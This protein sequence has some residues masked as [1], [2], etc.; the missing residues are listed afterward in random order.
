MW[1]SKKNL[2]RKVLKVKIQT[3]G[4]II[5][6]TN[7]G[8]NDKL[9]V[10][11]TAEHGII[12]AFADGVRRMKSKNSAATSLLCYSNFTLYQNKDT[13][14]VSDSSPIELFF[15]L[16]YHLEEL[17]LAQY[18]CDMALRLTPEEYE[19][20]EILRLLLNSL[21]FLT[22]QSKPLDI[23][24]AV[25][26]L[27][28]I[29]LAGFMPNLIGCAACDSE[30]AFRFSYS[31]GCLFCLECEKNLNDAVVLNPTV[32]AAMRHII[33]SDFSKIYSFEIPKKDAEILSAITEK[34]VSVQ[35]EY[36]FKTL[37]F[38]K[39]VKEPTL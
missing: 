5:K 24:K 17:A 30:Q 22:N 13:Y 35:S 6:E 10:I 33:Y 12:R 39:S 21:H 31:E 38:Y 1:Q 8:E 27:K 34:Y 2:G 26:E 19:P 16:R 9:L 28:L 3:P 15:D 32:L 14:K 7:I 29:S 18:F 11:L 20:T 4:L 37:D 25:T 36:R 23:I